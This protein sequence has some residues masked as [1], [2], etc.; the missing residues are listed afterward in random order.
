[1]IPIGENYSFADCTNSETFVKLISNCSRKTLV[2]LILKTN[3]FLININHE[4]IFIWI[5][6]QPQTPKP[7]LNLKI[8]PKTKSPKN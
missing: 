6:K 8:S 1:M 3:H 5:T 4:K 2:C 7:K